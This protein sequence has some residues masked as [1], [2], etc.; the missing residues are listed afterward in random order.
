MRS[1][2]SSGLTWLRLRP[3]L[4]YRPIVLAHNLACGVI[5]NRLILSEIKR[6]MILATDDLGLTKAPV[7][8]INIGA[9]IWKFKLLLFYLFSLNFDLPGQFGGI[10]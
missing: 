9:Q 2:Q 1:R 7:G 4:R 3:T 8:N 5:T 6:L 10:Q